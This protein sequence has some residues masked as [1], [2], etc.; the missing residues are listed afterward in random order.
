MERFWLKNYPPG[1]PH[2]IDTDQY[3]SLTDLMEQSFRTHGD[4][5]FS[6]CMNRWM[7]YKQLDQLSTALGAWLQNKGL[8]PGSRV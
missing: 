8:E 7:S 1:V 4:N 5:P 2:D 6:V 3:K